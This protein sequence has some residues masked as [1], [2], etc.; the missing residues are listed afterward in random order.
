MGNNTT[1][2]LGCGSCHCVA[3]QVTR[4]SV[5]LGVGW[6]VPKQ[7]YREIFSLRSYISSREG[8]SGL[9][10]GDICLASREQ[11]HG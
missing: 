1:G 10:L 11:G 6:E 2:G 5:L 9:F 8:G 7:Q 3:G 4:F